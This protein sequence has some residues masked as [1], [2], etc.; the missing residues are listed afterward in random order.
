MVYRIGQDRDYTV[1]RDGQHFRVV[2]RQYAIF[3]Q[4]SGKLV[5]SAPVL[6]ARIAES[7]TVKRNRLPDFFGGDPLN[8][9][10]TVTRPVR[11]RGDAEVLSVQ[12]R[13]D[14]ASGFS[15][16]PAEQIELSEDWQP[17]DG[18]VHVGDPLK[19]TVIIR[20]RGV[21]GEQLP[22]LDLNDTKG[23]KVYPD[24]PKINTTDLAQNIEG[25]KSRS[26]AYVPVQPGRFILPAIKLQ[27]WDTKNNQV[28]VSQL[29]ERI[30]EILPV[31]NAENISMESAANSADNAKSFV[32]DE[33]DA[34]PSA[35]GNS[36]SGLFDKATAEQ[37]ST[38]TSIWPWLSI[39]FA[40]LWLATMG[41]WR[42][43]KRH[44]SHDNLAPSAG[45]CNQESIREAKKL[46]Q[47]A[48][49]AND[50]MM[51]R[52]RLLEWAAS[53][54]PDDPPAGLDDLARRFVDPRVKA[55]LEELDRSLFRD[56]NHQWSGSQLIN[57]INKLPQCARQHYK[58]TTLPDLYV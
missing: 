20:A 24:Q 12:P 56:E 26:I 9:M 44:Q 7:S 40:L 10:F 19:R 21:T 54:W 33:S 14:E 31:R 27:W 1:E 13:P 42:L 3:P 41:M 25:E 32:Y 39:L 11:V 45:I 52:R 51:A 43:S 28:R 58:K 35:R 50:P 16:L 29:P 36:I 2:E 23:F 47:S 38:Q 30:V 37:M 6:D 17:Q 18:E 49:K 8:S 5:L 48:C 55:A 46:F 57:L 15:W 22:D 34:Q 53:H 4:T